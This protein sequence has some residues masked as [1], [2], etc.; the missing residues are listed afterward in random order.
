MLVGDHFG[1]P[2]HVG[3]KEGAPS[4]GFF[5]EPRCPNLEVEWRGSEKVRLRG[6]WGD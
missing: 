3:D 2:V 5:W 6:I 1:P 4:A